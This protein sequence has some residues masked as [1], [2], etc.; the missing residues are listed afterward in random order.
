[1]AASPKKKARVREETGFV[2]RLQEAGLH[3]TVTGSVGPPSDAA[4]CC[5]Q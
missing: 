5:L 1:M 3:T 2:H 4:G